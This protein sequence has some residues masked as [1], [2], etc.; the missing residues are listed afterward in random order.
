[1]TFVR[2]QAGLLRSARSWGVLV[3]LLALAVLTV[4]YGQGDKQSPQVTQSG[5]LAVES[6]AS[7]P[8]GAGSYSRHARN[9]ALAQQPLP[10]VPPPP[11]LVAWWPMD[12]NPL[13]LW[14]SHNPSATNAITFVPGMVGQGVTFGTGGYIDIPHSP[15][16]ANQQFTIDAWVKPQGPGPNNDFWGS[17]IV[18]KGRSAPTGYTDVPI[19]LWWSAQNAQQ[20]K[21][22]FTFGDQNTERI[23]STSTFPAGQW[24]H[25]AATYDGSD[26]KLYV[27]GAL[28][29]TMPLA[30]TIVYDPA[31][32]WTI[33]STASHIRT[34]GYPRTFNGVIDEV[35]IFNRALTAQEV[36][37]IHQAGPAGKCKC[38]TVS[39]GQIACNPNG[40]FS[41]TATLTNVTNAVVTGI[42]L[43]PPA[44]VTITPSSITTSLSPG[45]SVTGTVTIGG[46]N[47]QPG[48]TVCV[49]I[50]LT[51]QGV[52]TCQTKHCVTLPTCPGPGPCAQ[53][54]AGMVSWWPLDDAV[55]QST[56]QDLVGGNNGTTKDSTGTPLN[57][58]LGA[59]PQVVS[60][61]P[62]PNILGGTLTP[63]VVDP[64]TSP[65]RGA[66]FFNRS[67]TEVPHHSSLNIGPNGITITFWAFASPTPIART[68]LLEKFD[69]SSTN[70]Y[71]LYLEVNSPTTY[72]LKMNLNGTILTG[73]SVPQ[74]LSPSDWR[75]IAAR[76]SATGT[77]TLAV[78]DLGGSCSTTTATVSSFVTTNTAP[79]W[80]GRSAVAYPGAVVAALALALD[81]IE[82]FNR[83]LTQAELQSIYDAERQGRRKCPCVP[84]PPDM[85]AWYPLD[86]QNGATTVSDIA[87]PPAST[88]SDTGIPKPGP[89]GSGGPNPVPGKVG[90]GALY[91]FGP[92]V[93]VPPSADLTF[94]GDFSIDAWIRVVECGMSGGGVLAPIVD[95]WDPT[96]QTGFSL[97]VDQ[98]SPSTGFLK[99][100]LN[101]MLFTSTGS[102]PTGANP[103]ANTGPWVHVAV[104]V[105][106][107]SGVGTFYINGTPAGTFTVPAGSITNALT[108]L[109]GEIRVP[110]GRCEL[111]ID[112]LELFN[113]VLTPQEVQDIFNAGSAGKCRPQPGQTGQICV[114]KFEDLD[115]DGVQDPNEPLLPN[116]VFNVTDPSNNPVG[117]ITTTPP[118][119]PPACLTVAAPGTY[120]VTE[121]VQSGW[122]PTT[123]N[124]QTVTVQ[125]GQTV[126]V[127]FGNQGKAEICIF[128]F[129][130][131]DGDGKQGPN[132]PPLAGWQF[133][134]SPTPL[135]PTT[136]PVTTGPQG[137]IC[138]GVTAPG[139]YTITEQ[140]QSGWT[141]TTPNPQTVTVTPGQLVKV[142]FGNQQVGKCDLAIKKTVDPNPPVAGQPFA[143]TVT[144]TNVGDGPCAPTTTVTDNLP[145]GFMVT[146]FNPNTAGGWTCPSGPPGIVCNNPTLTLQPGQSSM[147]FA[148][149]GTMSPGISIENC[150]ELK[151]PNDTNPNNNKDCIKVTVVGKCDLKIT[152]TVQPNP[153]PSGQQVTITLTVQNVGTAPCPPGP[154]PGT[155][156]RD[157][158]PTGIGS[159]TLTPATA[160][161]GWQCGLEVPSGNLTCATPNT[162]P[163]GYSAT[164]TFT[165]TVTAPPGSQIQN[166]AT[167]NNQNDPLNPANPGNNQSCVT[168]NVIGLPPPPPDLALV[169]LLDG[170]LRV[171]QEA[172]YVLRVANGGGG[173]TSG[174]IVVSDPLPSGLRFVSA[175]G[176]GWS[177]A[178]QGQNVTCRNAGPIQP[179]QT[180]TILLRVR[181]AAPAGTQITNCATVETAGDANPANNRACHTGT[182]QR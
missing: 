73:P 85:V 53:A 118:G 134:V 131:L 77:V 157:N 102:L 44:G 84:P 155:I 133:T 143:F 80:F 52:V 114:T 60:Q 124:P 130:D 132:E 34:V 64:S 95:K 111:A 164:F 105:D 121:Q 94:T 43:V 40:T 89:V 35:E 165:G 63:V 58:S 69:V 166:C 7:A 10:C 3:L 108:M 176:P 56:V 50:V 182:V 136:S 158:K 156:V 39:N 62:A 57:I 169:K 36:Q 135:P 25:V 162:L 137:S 144:V 65:L 17:V 142:F 74:G 6:S 38:A 110:G 1:M 32:P 175:S 86:E 27:N 66:L 8:M 22:G 28:E 2:K 117:T 13:D 41:Y 5:L 120:T 81:E 98:P 19:S 161:A 12:G 179:G 122:T 31:I 107:T 82:I 170:Q 83:A 177:C 61:L 47:A 26:F 174:P 72:A 54:P 59:G 55:G 160:P 79:L 154:F 159:F 139:T 104:T 87:S 88:V 49:D 119:T 100:Q 167:V 16:L 127:T 115:G 11:G 152:K 141:V 46:P 71:S 150:A 68:P 149:V 42:N 126:N 14:A 78:C 123:P 153:V 128:K 109:I 125:P 129:N 147:V 23:V 67:F 70:G 181:V 96:T 51:T 76:V 113:R 24:Y 168:I 103:L 20:E 4:G 146:S 75:F 101:N 91:F 173:P 37:A 172:T 92:F 163:V 178:A 30:K 171:E 18:Q 140:V 106:R 21:F 180:S 90:A 116:W 151:N 15:A 33:G 93:E 29:G 48:S 148:V 145:I 99:L 9:A 45:Q 97:F 112:E 138:F